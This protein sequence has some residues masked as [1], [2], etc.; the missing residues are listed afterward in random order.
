MREVR[1]HRWVGNGRGAAAGQ[2]IRGGVVAGY[3][4]VLVRAS[5]CSR[6]GGSDQGRGQSGGANEEG[7]SGQ[8]SGCIRTCSGTRCRR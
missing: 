4:L 7:G 5:K 6:W 1:E 2:G 8:D 3:R